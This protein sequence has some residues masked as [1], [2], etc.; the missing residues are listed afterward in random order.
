MMEKFKLK[1]GD[2]D[3][4]VEIS[5]LTEQASH[6]W[7]RSLDGNQDVATKLSGGYAMMPVLIGEIEGSMIYQ[8]TSYQTG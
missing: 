2:K 7:T 5:D 6:L 3:L 1:L 8:R 4:I